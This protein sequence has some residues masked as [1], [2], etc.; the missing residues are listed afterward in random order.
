MLPIIHKNMLKNR[1]FISSKSISLS[2]RRFIG[3]YEAGVFHVLYHW[4]K[5]DLP[6]DE[7]VFDIIAGTSI[8][9]INASIIINYFLEQ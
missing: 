3:A 1:P 2:R 7:N 9:A 6:E 8:G 4:I 5:K